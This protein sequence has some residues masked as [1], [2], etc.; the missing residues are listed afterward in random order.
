MATPIATKIKEAAEA[1]ANELQA[2]YRFLPTDDNIHKLVGAIMSLLYNQLD[3]TQPYQTAI[4]DVAS[5]FTPSLP[6]MNINTQRDIDNIFSNTVSTD[7]LVNYIR[8]YFS[9]F[10]ARSYEYLS[11]NIPSGLPNFIA[12]DINLSNP[13]PS[14]FDTFPSNI[15]SDVL[16]TDFVLLLYTDQMY[17]GTFD[18]SG[19]WTPS[20]QQENA[21]QKAIHD[22]GIQLDDSGHILEDKANG[23][24]IIKLISS[25]W[26][27]LV[28][29][30]G[31]NWFSS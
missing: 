15:T 11:A 23:E 13:L 27:Y 30:A 18:D 22:F 1:A 31:K 19:N 21:R 24:I 17:P 5:Q 12:E 16:K 10:A 14:Y 28:W 20:Q 25:G 7:P 29:F 3:N 2:Q 8:C 26:Y 4:N 6:T 9:H